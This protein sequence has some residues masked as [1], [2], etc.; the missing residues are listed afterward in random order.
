MPESI[1]HLKDLHEEHI[2]WMED[3]HYY[4]DEVGQFEK[5]LGSIAVKNTETDVRAQVQMFQSQFIRQKEVIDELHHDI[6]VKETELVEFV[7]E[8]HQAEVDHQRSEDHNSLRDRFLTFRNL[9]N[10]LKS[11]FQGFVG[12][13]S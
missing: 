4:K 7:D 5:T 2:Q 6:K 9:Y 11:D 12:Q 10:E 8:T 1:V 3:L 13:W